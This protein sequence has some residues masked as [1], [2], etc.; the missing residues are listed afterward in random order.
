MLHS[1]DK[2]YIVLHSYM[3]KQIA[4]AELN[5]LIC[6]RRKLPQTALDLWRFS[7]TNRKGSFLLE[8]VLHGKLICYLISCRYI[9]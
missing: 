8:P 2:F 3:K 9:S 6:K 7:R 4:G 5:K 1:T